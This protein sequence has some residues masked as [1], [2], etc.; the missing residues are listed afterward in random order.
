M[1][2]SAAAALVTLGQV[3]DHP[4]N[5]RPARDLVEPRGEDGIGFQPGR[6]SR[7]VGEDGLGDFLGELRRTNL[8]QRGAI[9]QVQMALDERGKGILRLVAGELSE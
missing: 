4:V 2:P 8:A 7:E 9:D 3:F 5:G 1:R 6:V